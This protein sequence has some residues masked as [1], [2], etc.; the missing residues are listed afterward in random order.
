[1]AQ[2]IPLSK[3]QNALHSSLGSRSPLSASGSSPTVASAKGPLID[4]ENPLVEK[5]RI[6]ST[7][8]SRERAVT[9]GNAVERANG[10]DQVRSDASLSAEPISYAKA[11]KD[12]SRI[13]R[14]PSSSSSAPH[15]TTI[16]DPDGTAVRDDSYPPPAPSTLMGKG[17]KPLMPAAR[18]RRSS[19]VKRKL[20][21]GAM[22]TKVVDWEIPRKT[23]HSSIGFLTLYLN[24]LNPRSL[25]QLIST[26]TVLLVGISLTD[27]FRLK[28]PTFADVWE[29]A[30]GFLMRESERD[31]VNG[32]VWYLLGVIWVLSL[33]PR[34]VA[35]VSILILSWSDTTASTIGRLWG[36]Y[37]PPLPSHFLGIKFL[38]FAPRKSLAGFLAA[39]V[40]GYLICIGFWWSGSNG[41]WIVLDMQGYRPWQWG[42]WATG[43]VVGVGGAIVEALDL[44]IDDNLTLPIL[45]GAIIWVWLA[46]TN[47]LLA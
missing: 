33:Y 22:P 37:T 12:P 28:Y 36:R 21:P 5:N 39:T 46:G 27:Y 31:K 13:V 18:R 26:L 40:T 45:S 34:D 9:N 11:R 2:V 7:G 14:P 38:P 20:S 23:F 43:G 44:G 29:L 4:K 47:W 24:Y 3:S 19:S 17:E 1:M 35:V 41:R 16:A 6:M 25:S 42:L 10:V 15:L 8:T 30:V 32:V